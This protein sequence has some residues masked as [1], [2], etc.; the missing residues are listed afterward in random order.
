MSMENHPFLTYHFEIQDLLKKNDKTILGRLILFSKQLW[1]DIHY[2]KWLKDFKKKF[3][4]E[5]K[6]SFHYD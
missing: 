6:Q 2:K 1:L 5:I 3:R 4:K